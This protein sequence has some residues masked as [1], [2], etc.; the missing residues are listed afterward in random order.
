M[1]V[2]ETDLE[3]RMARFEEACRKSGAKLTHQR[4]EIF[5]EVAQTG[6]HPDAERVFE[7]VR[8]RMPTIS[9][10]TVCRTLWWLKDLGLISVLNPSRERVRF[11]ANLNRHHHFV[12][13]LTG[14]LRPE[15]PLHVRPLVLLLSDRDSASGPQLSLL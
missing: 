15:K 11:D 8:K 13:R 3:Q 5:G 12:K 14:H 4:M 6:D 1:K 7:G 10:D 2:S 9:M